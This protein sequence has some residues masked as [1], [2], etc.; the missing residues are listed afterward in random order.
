GRGLWWRGRHGR[1]GR[2]MGA[3]G[4][5]GQAGEPVLHDSITTTVVKPP[6]IVNRLAFSGNRSA[7]G[8]PLPRALRL[9]AAHE[10]RWMVLAEHH[11]AV[12]HL[13]PGNARERL[14]D[15]AAGDR[16]E[17]RELVAIEVTHVGAAR[18][19]R[20]A[21]ERVGRRDRQWLRGRAEARPAPRLR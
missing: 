3:G 14:A 19:E 12:D 2:R 10:R 18:R 21:F 8:P 4:D 20:L 11:Q 6:R 9:R 15:R 5:E 13:A 1:G 16:T 7:P 17:A